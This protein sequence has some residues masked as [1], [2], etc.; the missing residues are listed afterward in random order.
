VP[1]D[2]AHC[3]L[4]GVNISEAEDLAIAGAAQSPI[5][6]LILDDPHFILDF[7]GEELIESTELIDVLNLNLVKV[8]SIE[9]SETKVHVLSHIRR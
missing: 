7:T 3:A 2:A 5:F 6:L 9:L 8:D 4:E 1:L